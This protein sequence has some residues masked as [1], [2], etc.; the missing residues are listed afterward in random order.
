MELLALGV[1]PFH[2]VVP[3]TALPVHA[4]RR[5]HVGDL[6]G[7]RYVLVARPQVV[8]PHQVPGDL[9]VVPDHRPVLLPAP[10]G[11]RPPVLVEPFLHKGTALVVREPFGDEVGHRPEEVRVP[12]V[13]GRQPQ[14]DEVRRR[15]VADRVPVLAGPVHRQRGRARVE[16]DGVDVREVPTLV[17]VEVEAVEQFH[18]H[19]R[20]TQDARVAGDP[21]RLHGTR[22]GVDLFVRRD[23]VVVVAELRG[24][25]LPFPAVPDVDR[26]VPVDDAL[27]LVHRAHVLAQV[28]G[29]P[30]GG[31]QVPVLTGQQVRGGEAVDQARDGVGLLAGTGY[32]APLDGEVRPVPAVVDVPVRELRVEVELRQ[33]ADLL[34]PPV[35]FL[36]AVLVLPLTEQDE[37]LRLE[38]RRLALG[39]VDTVRVE[40]TVGDQQLVQAAGRYLER[41]VE[42]AHDLRIRGG[43]QPD[44]ELPAVGGAQAERAGVRIEVDH[45]AGYR[46]REGE[47]HGAWSILSTRLARSGLRLP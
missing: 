3:A 35:R 4:H 20:V 10:R 12:F 39:V 44:T 19:L 31:L 16:V 8:Y 25:D 36:E 6:P 18:G 23:R 15:V 14:V 33:R 21:V 30:L 32:L 5:H 27:L 29:T 26:V 37:M 41:L 7:Q 24:E 46:V 34:G 22:E 47:V 42:V 43:G 45:V 2:H 13:A 17:A 11:V 40:V 28:L 1:H 38:L 9:Q